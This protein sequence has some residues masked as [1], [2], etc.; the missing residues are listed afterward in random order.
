MR[1]TGCPALNALSLTAR[2][3]KQSVSFTYCFDFRILKARDS[4][5]SVSLSQYIESQRR[6]ISSRN[7]ISSPSRTKKTDLTYRPII[8]ASTH[9]KER[10]R[11]VTDKEKS[12]K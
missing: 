10:K 7:S 2:K 8:Y 11:L 9:D 6:V 3:S 12:L 5:Q 1:D 4:E